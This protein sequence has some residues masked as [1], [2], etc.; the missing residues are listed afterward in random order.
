[1]TAINKRLPKSD[2]DGELLNINEGY[3]KAKRNV[4][5]WAAITFLIAIAFDTG[6][7]GLQISSIVRGIGFNQQ[8]VTGL[9]LITLVFMFIGYHRA[10]WHLLFR[11][12]PFTFAKTMSDAT[13]EAEQLVG[14]IREH[15]DD[16]KSAIKVAEAAQQAGTEYA[17][18]LTSTAFEVLEALEESSAQLTEQTVAEIEQG[19]ID[20]EA[21]LLNNAYPGGARDR[22]PRFEDARARLRQL[23][24]NTPKKVK[25]S[26][27]DVRPG[28]ALS[29]LNNKA[30]RGVIWS[31]SA[32]E[33]VDSEGNLNFEK[34]ED[35][36]ATLKGL[37]DRIDR[38]EKRLFYGYDRGVVWA[39][40]GVAAS[41][42]IARLIAPC[43]LDTLIYKV[44]PSTVLSCAL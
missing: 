9:A 43:W 16:L 5:F 38:R 2:E 19:L 40:T 25:S 29:R 11:N 41:V 23:L 8:M 4:L 7:A 34:I 17:A 1:M 32:N 35:L 22:T 14:L 42:A 31:R 10:E 28:S 15:K 30:R 3:R 20:V 44:D 6:G 36:A 12:S 39:A 24:D 13:A 21:T 33:T 26:A 27:L 18:E 37:S